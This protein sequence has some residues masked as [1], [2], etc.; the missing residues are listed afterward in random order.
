M[1]ILQVITSLGTGGAERLL[2]DS[3]PMYRERGIDMEVLLLNGNKTPFYEMMEHQ[4]IKIYSLTTG[5]LK[6]VYNPLLIWKI[7]PFL[8]R[9]DIVHVHLFPA[10]YWVAMAQML[11]FG[12]GPLIFTEHSTYNRRMHRR[13]WR[14]TDRLVYGQY[15]KIVSIT[16]DVRI[17]ICSYLHLNQSK[18]D[19]IHNGIN[20]KKFTPS[21]P[22]KKKNGVVTLIQ[23]A[24][25]RKE[26]DQQTV[27]RSLQYL[28]DN[29]CLLLVGDGETRPACESVVKKLELCDRVSFLG[30]RTDIQE[31][32]HASDIVILSS[33]GEG[34]GLSVVEGMAVGKPVIASDIPGL[35]LVV[36]GAGILFP[37]GDAR[38]L[39]DE[40]FKLITHSGYYNIV[41]SKC[42]ERSR[43]YD[44]HTMVNNY[45]ELYL[46]S[47]GC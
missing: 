41:A 1:K 23:V 11:S 15:S 37:P 42:L 44:I 8:K 16:D 45:I 36:K 25:F 12:K 31:L 13:F 17:R 6:K 46:R 39:A 24:G 34:F 14:M 18:F 10:L 21:V 40:I 43:M 5:H 33:H 47:A 38:G 26:K 20:L 28:P 7:I 22:G 4:D 19:I 35:H 27:I 30:V 9:Y 2:T 32:L 29:V 3:I